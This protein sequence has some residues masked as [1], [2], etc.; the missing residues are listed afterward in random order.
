M[1][2]EDLSAATAVIEDVMRP[3]ALS[4]SRD[5]YVVAFCLVSRFNS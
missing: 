4:A 1:A 2:M 3:I 5:E